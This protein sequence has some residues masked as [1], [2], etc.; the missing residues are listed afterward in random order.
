MALNHF[1]EMKGLLL[2]M[3]ILQFCMNMDW[4]VLLF[5]FILFNH[6]FKLWKIRDK[7]PNRYVWI[8]EA[9]LVQFFIMAF[10]SLIMT[11]YISPIFWYHLAISATREITKYHVDQKNLSIL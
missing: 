9:Q 3:I 11:T 1:E 8:G 4:L 5:I 10:V 6:F 2:I 7:I